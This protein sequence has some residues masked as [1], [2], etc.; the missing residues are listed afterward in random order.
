[1][2]IWKLLSGILFFSLGYQIVNAQELAEP[3]E[4]SIPVVSGF[5]IGG[6]ASTNGLG[7]HLQYIVNNWLTLRSGLESLNLSHSF[8]FDEDDISYD[9]KL[10]YKTGGLF[11]L[12]DLFYTRALYFSGGVVMN[13]FQ[14]KLEG[15]AVNDLQYGDITIPA[16]QVGDFS[17]IVTPEWKYS[18]Y[19]GLGARKLFG[20]NQ[21]VSW[22]IETGLYYMGDPDIYIESTGLLAP[23]SDP[24]LGREKYLESQFSAYKYYPVLKFSV[25]IRLF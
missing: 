9:S 13:D 2:K 10:T 23:T 12:A 4:P 3:S 18:P 17:L 25:A 8:L 5:Y 14:P 15:I 6:Q 16:A 24:A 7:F 22:N 1:M 19:L 21:G 20:K 11:L